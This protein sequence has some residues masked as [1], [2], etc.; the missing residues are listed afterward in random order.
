MEPSRII[1]KLFNKPPGIPEWWSPSIEKIILIDEPK[2]E[3]YNLV[4]III[5]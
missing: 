2:S 1:R 4:N 3:K 5:F